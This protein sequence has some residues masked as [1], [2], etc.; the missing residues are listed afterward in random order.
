VTTQVHSDIQRS[1]Q[2][3]EF[4]PEIASIH[5]SPKASLP[6]LLLQVFEDPVTGIRVYIFVIGQSTEV[7]EPIP[8]LLHVLPAHFDLQTLPHFGGSLHILKSQRNTLLAQHEK[9][10]IGAILTSAC[11][12]LSAK[13]FAFQRHL[14]VRLHDRRAAANRGVEGHLLTRYRIVVAIFQEDVLR[15]ATLPIAIPLVTKCTN[16]TVAKAHTLRIP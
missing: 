3:A 14:W 9:M 4:G 10:R 15:F 11:S 7:L 5:T 6:P 8:D 1:Q 2:G 12:I 13:P 16:W